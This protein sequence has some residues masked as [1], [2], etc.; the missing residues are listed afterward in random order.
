MNRKCVEIALLVCSEFIL[1]IYTSGL[2]T[3]AEERKHY[4]AARLRLSRSQSC[5]PF[6]QLRWEK[7][8]GTHRLKQMVNKRCEITH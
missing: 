8:E 4:S 2:N 6:V 5:Y 1:W 3:Q 7:N